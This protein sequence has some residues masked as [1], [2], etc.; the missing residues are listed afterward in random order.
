MTYK[1]TNGYLDVLTTYKQKIAF[2]YVPQSTSTSDVPD[3][4]NQ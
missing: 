1:Q 3:S 2:K 4:L